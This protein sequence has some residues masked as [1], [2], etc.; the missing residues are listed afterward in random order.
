MLIQNHD[1]PGVVGHG[2]DDARRRGS[3]T[4][5]GCSSALV[6]ERNE[7]AM[8]VN[9]TPIPEDSLMERLRGLSHVIDAQLVDL[10][11]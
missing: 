9:V 1:Q 7:A 4:F 6:R 10:G 8:L 5:P 3:A 2:R 11:S